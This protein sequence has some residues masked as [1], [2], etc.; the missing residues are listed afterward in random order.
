MSNIATNP[1]KAKQLITSAVILAAVAL[2]GF[3]LIKTHGTEEDKPETPQDP[4][5]VSV[6]ASGKKTAAI[7]TELAKTEIWQ[8]RIHT[9][10]LLSFPSDATLKITPKLTGRIRSVLVKVGDRVTPGQPLAVLESVDAATAQNTSRQAENTL[11]QAK[12]DL[13][14]YTRLQQL[15][16]PDVTAAKAALAQAEEGVALAKKVLDL[17]TYQDKIGGFT[18]KPLEDARNALVTATSALSQARADDA[19]AKKDL[20]RKQKLFDGGVVA[21]ADLEVSQDAFDKAEANL[22]QNED[23]VALAQAAV[24]RESKAFHSRL[25]ADQQLEQASG[26]YRQALLQRN[27]AATALRIAQTQIQRDLLQA[28]TAYRAAENE[29]DNA[30][31]AL[32]LLGNPSADGAITI[33][34][35]TAGIVT[36]RDVAPGQVV[37]QSQMA[38]WQLMVIGNDQTVWVDADVFEKDIASVAPGQPVSIRVAALPSREF[39]GHVLRV[40]PTLD[41]ASR[42]VKVRVEIPNPKRQLKDGEYA[43]VAIT[44]GSPHDALTIPWA[45][46]DHEGDEDFAFV[47]TGGK[48]AKRPIHVGLR[49][50]ERCQVLDGLKAGEKV[51]THGALFLGGQQSGD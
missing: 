35:P 47:E 34:A 31:R 40:A 32:T 2:M 25:Y 4:N 9:S 16:T 38:P 6:S 51:V 43:D 23:S 14:R 1:N 48:Y 17:A 8:D 20:A 26:A 36:E 19:L 46:V 5:L 13:D 30:H 22:K 29:A 28:T 11:R 15:G 21:K 27:A 37:D 12:L 3:G 50:G 18:E 24:E 49:E 7:E 39:K 33:A 42:A 10:G 45:G 41:K 44:V